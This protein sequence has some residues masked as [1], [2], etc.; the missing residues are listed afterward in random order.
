MFTKI[1]K[2]LGENL[3]SLFTYFKYDQDFLVLVLK[4]ADYKSLYESRNLLKEHNLIIMTEKDFSEGSDVFPIEFLDMQSSYKQI[5]GKDLLKKIKIV[6]K[7]L[8]DQ[9]EKELRSKRIHLKDQFIEGKE[10]EFLQKV[11]PTISPLIKALLFY[12]KQDFT[13][14]LDHNLSKFQELYKIDVTELKEI[15]KISTN[16]KIAKD[17]Y[18]NLIEGLDKFLTE[19]IIQIN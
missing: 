1:K 6:K 2:Q 9:L 12:K 14:Q 13:N 10:K 15:S 3:I 7:N 19:T 17:H 5:D 18:L 4:E 16:N 11:M 8:R